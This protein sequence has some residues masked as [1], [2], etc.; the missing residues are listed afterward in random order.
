MNTLKVLFHV[1]ESTRWQMV[2]VNITNFLNDVGQGSADIEV[3]ANGEAVSVLGNRCL[4]AEDG[5]Q[6]ASCGIGN[7]S[8]LDQMKKLSEAGVNFV[9][10]RNAL[11]SH[12]IVEE[13]L[14]DFIT[15]VPAGITEIVR[16]QTQGYAYIKP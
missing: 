1:N 9:V 12:S 11:K 7:G 10:C 5:G 16:K 3:L 6:K 4:L 15:V 2:L 8:L 13:N 14:P